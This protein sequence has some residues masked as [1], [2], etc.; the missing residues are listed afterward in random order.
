MEQS[1]E[2]SKIRYTR[3]RTKTNNEEW[4]SPEKLA[5]LGTQ[6]T[7]Q[8]KTMKNGTAGKNPS[9]AGWFSRPIK[10]QILVTPFTSVSK[11]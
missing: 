6:D 9:A 1:R 4:N 3:H 5:R 7:R 8:R 10:C 11:Y 2:T